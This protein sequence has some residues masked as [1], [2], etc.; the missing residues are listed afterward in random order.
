MLFA[1]EGVCVGE[2][3]VSEANGSQG[4]VS[5]RLNDV[6]ELA[7]LRITNVLSVTIDVDVV[8]ALFE[9]QF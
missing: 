5:V 7:S 1:T 4:F 6:F 2:V 3:A 8:R 9:N